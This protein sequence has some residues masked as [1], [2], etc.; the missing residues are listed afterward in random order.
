LYQELGNNTTTE[1]EDKMAKLIGKPLLIGDKY[2]IKS[3]ELNVTL[4]LKR[5]IT[6]T[7]R[8]KPSKKA[9]GE[10]YW[11][12]IA[13]FATP[14]NAL[15]YLVDNEVMGTGMTDLKTI[16]TKLEDLHTLIKGL[17]LP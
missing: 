7:S 9:I 8:L 14:K 17:N 4:F 16:V 10:E 1:K 5:R 15:D 3:D 12:P 2:K 13:Y 6:G 11:T